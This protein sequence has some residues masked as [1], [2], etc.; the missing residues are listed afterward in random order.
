VRASVHNQGAPIPADLLAHLFEPFSIG[1]RAEGTPRR[2]IGLGLFIVKEFVTAHGGG[3][4]VESTAQDG[5]RF[6]VRLPRRC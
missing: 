3:V 5:T 2:S 6:T 4:A 1:P